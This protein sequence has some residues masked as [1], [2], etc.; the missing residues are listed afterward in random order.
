MKKSYPFI[1]L[2]LIFLTLSI[3]ALTFY[4]RISIAEFLIVCSIAILIISYFIFSNVR[5]N[6]LSII[7]FIGCAC[8]FIY[9]I[10]NIVGS[11]S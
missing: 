3:V 6:V 10:A 1:L 8:C 5:Y 9:Q 2:A 7:V 11:I 4:D